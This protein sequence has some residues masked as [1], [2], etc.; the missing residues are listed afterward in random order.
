MDGLRNL[1]QHFGAILALR[2]DEELSKD[3][4]AAIM[5]DIEEEKQKKLQVL[6]RV[7]VKAIILGLVKPIAHSP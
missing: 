7:Y 1:N 4:R 6:S 3:E 5:A 2:F